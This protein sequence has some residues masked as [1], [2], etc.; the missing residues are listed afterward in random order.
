MDP[1]AV[2][3]SGVKRVLL[4]AMRATLFEL[5]VYTSEKLLDFYMGLYMNVCL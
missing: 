2:V 3:L 5:V 1:G 4:F